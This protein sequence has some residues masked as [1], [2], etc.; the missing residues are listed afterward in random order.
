MVIRPSLL[1]FSAL[2]SA[3]VP[4]SAQNLSAQDVLP[5]D[6]KGTYVLSSLQE[7]AWWANLSSQDQ[8]ELSQLFHTPW[9][10]KL[11]TK[12]KIAYCYV[13]SKFYDFL[14]SGIDSNPEDSYKS[15][16]PLLLRTSF[17]SSGTYHHGSGAGGSNGGTIFN[18]AELDDDTNGCVQTATD[19][20]NLRLN[21]SEIVSLAD[22]V[23]I[24]GV[25]AL[26]V[27]DFPR[28]DLIKVQGGRVDVD[29]IAYVESLASPDNDPMTHFMTMYDLTISELVAVIG[30]GHN[31][32]AAHGKCSGYTGQWTNSPLSWSN[33]TTGV[34]DFF[35]DLLKD[36]W[37]WRKVCT[38]QNDTAS[39]TTIP[40]PFAEGAPKAV[41]DTT[42]PST[43]RTEQSLD[44]INCEAQAMRGCDFEDGVYPIA[45]FPCD[46]NLLQM[47][48]RSDFFLKVNV[49]MRPYAEK[50]AN[51]HD[52][53]AQE[54]G[55]AYRKLT[56][57]GL[58]RCGLSGGACDSGTQ[59]ITQ[60]D[61]ETGRYLSSSCISFTNNEY[62]SDEYGYGLSHGASVVVILLLVCTTLLSIV[63]GFKV[64]RNDVKV[65]PNVEDEKTD[66]DGGM[67][68]DAE[69][70]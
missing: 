36:D 50:F 11:E 65:P 49:K 24:A 55:T 43:C 42:P 48:L 45:A 52:L 16:A 7:A 32:G 9:F 64:M 69:F 1:C 41:D 17:H 21:S 54:F 70:S 56:H 40:D 28:M 25:V 46:V 57:N 67:T 13:A 38:Y 18:Q 66:S 51:D 23:I 10:D 39:Y 30:G 6:S 35:V 12:E 20:I 26:D 4:V 59:C 37:S 3:A 60:T 15:F 63:L 33:R 58:D 47:R 29:R 22:A 61:T 8:E 27:M 5:N 19:A 34:P 53:L 2:F 31:F 44:P 14:E 62:A 68:E